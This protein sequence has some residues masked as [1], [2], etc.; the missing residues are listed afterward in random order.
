MKS[1]TEVNSVVENAAGSIMPNEQLLF[2][3]P[4]NLIIDEDLD[5]R[6]AESVAGELSDDEL[7]AS[8]KSDGQIQSV[9]LRRAEDGLHVVAGRRRV[10]QIMALNM[11][12]EAGSEA[13]R[14]M[15]IV[16]DMTEDEAF[17][18]A[19]MENL[20]RKNLTAIEDAKLCQKI[21]A[22]FKWNGGKNSKKVAEFL[23]KSPAWVTE[24][25]KLLAL[26]ETV[27]AD[28]L[29][30]KLS[31]DGAQALTKVEPGK[32]KEVVEKAQ[33]LQ[34]TENAK[35]GQMATVKDGKIVPIKA[36]HVKAAAREE[37]ANKP[38]EKYKPL[39]NGEIVDFF[40]GYRN[41]VPHLYPVIQEFVIY[42]LDKFVTGQGSGRTMT[43][44]TD[45][46][47]APACKGEKCD[48]EVDEVMV[49][50]AEKVKAAQEKE[51]A[52]AKVKADKLAA[53][54]KAVADKK[55]AAK[56]KK[57]AAK[58]AKLAAKAA[59]KPAGKKAG[60]RASKA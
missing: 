11:E 56:A 10:R 20:H 30:G 60:K 47:L 51:A 37:K 55:A 13:K 16:T 28:I 2:E 15:C 38:E 45:A 29:A 36:R 25:E 6:S 57:D 43:A 34:I 41:S 5:V 53:K 4:E 8:L 14:V 32:V 18:Q 52:K 9:K 48:P 7:K 40:A 58:A 54:A 17:R 23:G 46:V 59:K 50:K 49:A 39:T 26:P 3:L 24:R 44:K 27:Q 22:R 31:A 19:A 21:R 33:K 1:E 12:A 35:K 42:F